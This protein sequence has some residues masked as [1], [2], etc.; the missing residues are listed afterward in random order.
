MTGRHPVRFVGRTHASSV[1]SAP[2]SSDGAEA[3]DTLLVPE[4][5]SALPN[6]AVEVHAALLT[7][8]VFRFPDESAVDVPVPSL[9]PYAATSPVAAAPARSALGHSRIAK[10]HRVETIR[11]V[12]VCRYQA[13]GWRV[14]S[15]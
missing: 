9:N 2:R 5:V 7:V 14:P 12:N 10:P 6:L 8:P 1:I 4:N 11:S 3:T 15:E 13:I